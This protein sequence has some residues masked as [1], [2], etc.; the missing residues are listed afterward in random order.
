MKREAPIHFANALTR[1]GR[2]FEFVAL[3]RQK[4]GPRDPAARLYANTRFPWFCEK[5]L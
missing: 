1:A 4:D 5:N 2:D 3:R